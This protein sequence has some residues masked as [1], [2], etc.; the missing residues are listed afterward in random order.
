MKNSEIIARMARLFK[1]E[2]FKASNSSQARALAGRKG[3]G[4]SSRIMEILLHV[5]CG[6]CAVYSLDALRAEDLLVNG[7][8]YNPN[9]HPLAEYRRRLDTLERYAAAQEMPLRCE[10]GWPVEDWLRAVAGNEGPERCR[11]C[12]RIRLERSARICAGRGLSAFTTTLLYSKY[13]RHDWVRQEGERAAALFGVEFIYRDLRL[14][15]KEGV[16]RS[17]ELGMYRQQ[18]CGCLLSERDRWG[19]R[20][21]QGHQPRSGTPEP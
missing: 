18:Y 7:L 6:P 21:W 12:Y 16:R 3:T 13:Q 11:F 9:V 1:Q 17:K 8:F 20:G 15:W 19:G 5:C 2:G 10:P 14:G 4:V